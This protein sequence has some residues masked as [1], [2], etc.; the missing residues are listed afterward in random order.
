[1]K[2]ATSPRI[3]KCSRYTEADVL[4]GLEYEIRV[5]SHNEEF[6]HFCSDIDYLLGLKSVE[7]L[8]PLM[9]QKLGTMGKA[10]PLP[11]NVTD[12]Q[13]IKFCKSRYVQEPADCERWYDILKQYAEKYEADTCDQLQEI[14][15]NMDDNEQSDE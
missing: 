3:Y 4:N 8:D 6:V 15:D 9:L 13:L 2:E 12:D 7:G 1:M 11:Q 10:Q 14:Y 5:D